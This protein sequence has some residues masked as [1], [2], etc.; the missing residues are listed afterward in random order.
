MDEGDEGSVTTT[1]VRAEIEGVADEAFRV[2]QELGSADRDATAGD[3][4]GSIGRPASS[5]QDATPLTATQGVG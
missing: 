3:A 4:A 2:L 1:D 5:D